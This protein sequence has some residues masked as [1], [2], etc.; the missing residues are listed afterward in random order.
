LLPNW[1]LLNQGGAFGAAL[2]ACGLAAGP[3][4][5]PALYVSLFP[6]AHKFPRL[7]SYAGKGDGLTLQIQVFTDGANQHVELAY[8]RSAFDVEWRRNYAHL[9]DVQFMTAIDLKRY[10]SGYPELDRAADVRNPDLF[11]WLAGSGPLLGVEITAHSPDGSNIEKRY[12]FLWAARREGLSAFV[13]TPYLKR[14]P[15]GAVNRL[16]HRHARHNRDLARAWDPADPDSSIQQLLPVSDLTGGDLD[17]VPSAIARQLWSWQRIGKLLA[18]LAAQRV[19]PSEGALSRLLAAR[20]DLEHLAQTCMEFTT[21]TGAST[22]LKERDRWIQVFNA[23]PET[24]WWERGEGQFDSIDG[25]VMFTSAQLELMPRRL[26]P[27]SF[28]MWLPQM[29]SQHPWIREQVLGGYGSKR[30]RNLAQLLPQAD[31]DVPFRLVFADEMGPQDWALLHANPSMC[32]ERLISHEPPVFNLSAASHDCRV[33]IKEAA[34]SQRDVAEIRNLASDPSIWISTSRAYVLDWETSFNLNLNSLAKR[35]TL[36]VPRIPS[37]LLRQF[38][39]G[40]GTTIHGAE[41]CSRPL[42]LLLRHLHRYGPGVIA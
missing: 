17:L 20:S 40:A 14:R 29:T 13:A 27:K 24:G 26:R 11:F 7:V 8:I 12:P 31:L 4:A 28:E 19:S 10:A 21:D 30:F 39:V 35:S 38:T 23:R 1:P 6:C 25:R 22:L 37:R 36:F 18:A 9:P 42:L 16:P 41:D 3:C 33:P 5:P 34:R 2:R 15:G 32:L